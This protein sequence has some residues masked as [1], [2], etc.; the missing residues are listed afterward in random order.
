MRIPAKKTVDACQIFRRH[1]KN[2]DVSNVLLFF[3][4]RLDM[5]LILRLFQTTFKVVS[6]PTNDNKHMR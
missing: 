3:L 5:D 6:T 4:P 1:R 2:I